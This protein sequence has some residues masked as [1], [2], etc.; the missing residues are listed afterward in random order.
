MPETIHGVIIYHAAGLHV[1]VANCRAHELEAA[2]F[3]I[4]AH[5]VGFR[6]G[7]RN[8][9]MYFPAVLKRRA[10]NE[11]PQVVIETVLIRLLPNLKNV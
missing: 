5:G 3:E 9:L 7:G 8:L 11:L 6:R 2:F 4:F 10:A 1:C